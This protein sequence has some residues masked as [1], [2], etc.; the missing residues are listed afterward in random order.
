MTV[1]PQASNS[2]EAGGDNSPEAIEAIIGVYADTYRGPHG[3]APEPEPI[4]GDAAAE[5][6][7]PA[8]LVSSA[9]LAAHRE[10]GQ[11]RKPD[12]TNIAAHL[13]EDTDGFG[14]ALQLVT[15]QAPTL[16]ESVNVLL[17]R[18]GVAYL[19]IMSPV[20]RV[21]R[22]AEGELIDMTPATEDA[23]D[24]VDE[25][26]IH[27]QLAPSVDLKAVAK[28]ERL[29]PSVLADARQVA[30]DSPAMTDA[31]R[32]LAD[33]LDSETS[34][35]FPAADRHEVAELLRWLVDGHFV[36]V[37]YQR[38]SVCDGDAGVDDGSR[39]GVLRQRQD[40]FPQLT[41][42]DELLVLAQATIPSYLRYGAYPYVV[43]IRDNSGDQAVEHRLVGM[44]TVAAMNANVLEIPVISRR[45]N[46]ALAKSGQDQ[47]SLPGQLL[48]DV[49]QT[50][51][52]SELFALDAEELL[53]M[54]TAVIDIGSRR[55]TLLFLRG[56]QL[57]HF[58]SAL[59]YLPRDRYTTAVRLEMQDILVREFGGTSIDYTAR[60]SE[61]PWAVVHFT[62]RLPD[63]SPPAKIDTSEDN[64]L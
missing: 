6:T 56:D 16:M 14:P 64:R 51:P 34:S 59:V 3:D 11:R 62:V 46:A 9:I 10:L 41:E 55:R 44:F 39:L 52:R 25:A 1:R 29:L 12:T 42:S 27:V 43:V 26:W 63:D 15:D 19:A 2:L 58:V 37:G 23:G 35:R 22:G 57:G 32:T 45:V 18:L 21:H 61:S 28:A 4:A 24:G 13:D 54:A 53:A 40:D 48:L 33:A 31:L 20:F 30:C 38:C 17:H 8:E 5:H 47:S 7:G 50:F 49:I 60:V 36:L